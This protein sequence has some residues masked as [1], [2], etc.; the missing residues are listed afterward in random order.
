MIVGIDPD[1][2]KS[3]VCMLDSTGRI[4][5]LDSLTI[6]DL[7]A[8]IEWNKDAVYAIEDVTKNKAIYGRCMKDYAKTAK[9]QSVGMVKAAATLITE[10]V[11]EMTERKI[12]LA[13]V[14]LGKQV[15]NNA[16]LF[17]E[18]TGYKK[19]TNEDKRDAWAIAYW[20]FKNSERLVKPL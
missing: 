3:G 17:K 15:K 11:E 8:F 2:R 13:P 1:M 5:T 7:M 4:M 12:I 10:I 20:V 9:A 19:Q 14:G 16:E 18:I 6:V